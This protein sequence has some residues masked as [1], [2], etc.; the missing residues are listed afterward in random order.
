VSRATL[1]QD[2]QRIADLGLARPAPRA[3]LEQC[4]A[5]R[6]GPGRE[7]VRVRFEGRQSVLVLDQASSG[8]RT[9]RIFVCGSDRPAATTTVRVD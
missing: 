5:P 4:A 2:V 3:G 6:L 9:A 1:E 7:V 8:R